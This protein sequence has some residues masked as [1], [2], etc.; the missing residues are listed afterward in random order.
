[1]PVGD[2][3]VPRG[4]PVTYGMSPFTVG[5][6]AQGSIDG[7]LHGRSECS[8]DVVKRVVIDVIKKGKAPNRDHV[9]MATQ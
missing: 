8:H 2:G 3:T 6:Y 5:Y 4:T 1:V 7:V 9:D